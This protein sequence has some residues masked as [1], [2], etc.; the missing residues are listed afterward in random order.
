MR[1]AA[2]TR[3]CRK[4]GNK[5]CCRQGKD[6]V[7]SVGSM[8]VVAPN[9][10]RRS[11]QKKG[12]LEMVPRGGWRC[13][14]SSSERRICGE[15]RPPTSQWTRGANCQS[16]QICVSGGSVRSAVCQRQGDIAHERQRS[17]SSSSSS[18]RVYGCRVARFGSVCMCKCADA[19]RCE[20]GGRGWRRARPV[21]FVKSPTSKGSGRHDAAVSGWPRP[22]KAGGGRTPAGTR[23]P[24]TSIHGN[25]FGRNT[26]LS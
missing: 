24:S 13:N 20:L 18:S 7:A 4:S 2:K 3:R 10:R 16:A 25:A 15:E 9:G 26:E 22:R 8:V 1:A 23:A 19:L 21:S 11:L 5:T 12:A 14:S 6:S 17:A